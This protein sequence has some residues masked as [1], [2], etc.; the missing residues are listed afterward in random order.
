[1]WDRIKIINMKIDYHKIMQ[2][3]ISVLGWYSDTKRTSVNYFR[4]LEQDIQE[5][6]V[7]D[8]R[9]QES[10]LEHVGSL[11]VIAIFFYP[12]I[13]EEVNLW[14]VLEMLAI[15]DIWELV[16]GDEIVFT[17]K[18]KNDETE[19]KA[20]LELLDTRYHPIYQEFKKCKTNEA[21]FAKSIDKIAPDILDIVTDPLVT[22]KR[23]KHYANMNAE[24][25]VDRVEQA[26]YP[27][28]QWST[29]FR[30]FHAELIKDLRIKIA[31]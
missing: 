27:Y 9:V 14:R 31:Q 18:K 28:M 15:H 12:Y 26:K 10:L 20:A 24:E 25:I 17:K 1:M 7:W 11:P 2:E 29:F 3:L 21:R 8:A 23:L 22:I 6:T 13:E 5:Y 30:S 16:T 4:Y 19:E